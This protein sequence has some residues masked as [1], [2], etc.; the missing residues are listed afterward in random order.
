MRTATIFVL[1]MTVAWIPLKGDWQYTKWNMSESQVIEASGGIAHREQRTSGNVLVAPYK[2]DDFA[3]TATFI[4]DKTGGLDTVSLKLENADFVKAVKLR[5][6][7]SS[8][9]GKP[10]KEEGSMTDPDKPGGD[11]DTRNA[12]VEWWTETDHIR[13]NF[14][15]IEPSF[16]IKVMAAQRNTPLPPPTYDI[17]VS[18][19]TVHP[20]GLEGL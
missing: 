10:G 6:A 15:S 11:L 12:S 18:Y 7:L 16:R 8:K 2:T 19:S 4:F 1:S 9:Y 17:S 14:F 3:F 5:A 20:K 13:W